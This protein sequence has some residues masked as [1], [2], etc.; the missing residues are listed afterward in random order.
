MLPLTPKFTVC[1][2]QMPL[3]VY[4]EV[5]AHLQQVEGVKVVSIE[6]RDRIFSY[7]ESQLG[8]LEIIGVD[9]LTDLARSRIEQLLS[10]YA[11]RYGVWQIDS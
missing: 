11:D 3:A 10:Y 1:N 8:G 5:A 4:R 9:R 7:T 2:D 6:P